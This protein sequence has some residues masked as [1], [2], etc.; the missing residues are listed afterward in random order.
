SSFGKIES[1][2]PE[3]GRF[4]DSISLGRPSTIP[5]GRARYNSSCDELGVSLDDGVI[6]RSAD[7]HFSLNASS[8]YAARVR[9]WIEDWHQCQWPLDSVTRGV[10]EEW[11]VSTVAGPKARE[12][13]RAAGRALPPA[14][15]DFPHSSVAETTLDGHRLR[16]Q[17]V[18]FT[19]ELS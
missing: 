7:D 17:R 8:G 2:G 11:A 16:I 14:S 1:K 5:V 18:S 19:G 13:V 9:G 6:A 12:V 4:L 3:A 15:A 10:T